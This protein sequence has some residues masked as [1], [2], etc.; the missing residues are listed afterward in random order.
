M[1]KKILFHAEQLNLRGT[2]NS[3]LEY[4][5]YNQEILG[6]ESAIMYSASNPDGVD[7]GTDESVV[8]QLRGIFPL[9]TYSDFKEANEIASNFDLCYSQ[10]AG[11]K[12]DFR[13]REPQLIIDST[14]FGVHSVFQ[15]YDP[16]GDRYAYISEWLAKKIAN[17]YNAP[18]QSWVPY[19]VHMPPPNYDTKSHLGISK[20]K[21]VIGRSGGYNTFDI[22]YVKDTIGKVLEERD[23]I[24]FLFANTE[25]FIDHPNAIF[26]GP[27]PYPREPP[28]PRRSSGFSLGERQLVSY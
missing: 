22:Q 25:K 17:D 23:D 8:D 7:V 11:L 26:M 10:R 16:H 13:T 6:N 18:E 15:W 28:D 5:K 24:V 4:A 2:T 12:A 3:I 14:K 20:D 27:F 21:F 9:Y 19:V 1:P